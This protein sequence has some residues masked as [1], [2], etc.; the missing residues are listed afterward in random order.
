[1]YHNVVLLTHICTATPDSLASGPSLPV[2]HDH[3][4]SADAPVPEPARSVHRVEFAKSKATPRSALRADST[5][6]AN[7]QRKVDKEQGEGKAGSSS[8]SKAVPDAPSAVV[9][10]KEPK[11][12]KKK[13]VERE[14]VSA[15]EEAPVHAKAVSKP[16][17]KHAKTAK[18][19]ED[20]T[21]I[22]IT[23]KPTA[24]E[25]LLVGTPNKD[26]KS[27]KKRKVVESVEDADV[28]IASK[29]VPEVA[30]AGDMS[31]VPAKV[32]KKS[33]KKRKTETPQ[34]ETDADTVPQPV[35]EASETSE[36]RKSKKKRKQEDGPAESGAE[37]APKAAP[38]PAAVVDATSGDKKGKKRKSVAD[39]VATDSAEATSTSP[40]PSA[41]DCAKAV[42]DAVAA[43]RARYIKSAQATESE[44]RPETPQAAQEGW[45]AAFS[46]CL[47]LMV[48]VEPNPDPVAG[49]S[50]VPVDAPAKGKNLRIALL[51]SL[52]RRSYRDPQV[53][54]GQ[55]NR[56][57][58]FDL[59]RHT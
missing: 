17:K 38:E 36:K 57:Y 49:P 55:G 52:N 22:A 7:A 45:C 59:S 48:F 27:K 10:A 4:P 20:Q 58:T 5:S 33:K 35:I 16:E 26:K 31:S 28:L 46:I 56:W 19:A 29:P 14:G 21:A 40:A 25:D 3:E 34:E 6:S 39:A 30:E 37:A 44:S 24:A 18:R 53:Q 9:E 1:M 32:E 8:P 50:T 12:K 15:Q 13:E 51:P 2:A 54:E 42:A 11:T 47:S 41:L 23:P 43:I